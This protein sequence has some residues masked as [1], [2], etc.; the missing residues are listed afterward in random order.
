MG[1]ELTKRLAYCLQILGQVASLQYV[2]FE[3]LLLLS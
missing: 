2:S 1:F 3:K